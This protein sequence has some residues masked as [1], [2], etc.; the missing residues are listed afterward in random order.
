MFVGFMANS[1]P[2]TYRMYIPARNSIHVTR[3]VQWSKK[4]YNGPEKKRFHTCSGFGAGKSEERTFT[5]T[6][7]CGSNGASTRS[8]AN[9]GQTAAQA[10]SVSM[11]PK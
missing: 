1:S 11:I 2:D 10:A 9:S 3:E 5:H 6:C 7:A 4:M 8:T